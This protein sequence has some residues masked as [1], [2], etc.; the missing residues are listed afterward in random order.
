LLLYEL[1]FLEQEKK[2]FEHEM[3]IL[4]ETGTGLSSM[5]QKL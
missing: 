4:P 5:L 2:I 1:L 3:E